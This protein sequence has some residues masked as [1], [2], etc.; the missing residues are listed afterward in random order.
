MTAEQVVYLAICIATLYA[1]LHLQRYRF[2]NHGCGPFC[3]FTILSWAV[4]WEAVDC[5]VY[6]PPGFPA[7]RWLLMP[8]LAAIFSWAA[9]EDWQKRRP[10]TRQ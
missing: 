6:G 2:L 10:A 9:V 3:A 7:S 5:W 1:I 4:A 8:S